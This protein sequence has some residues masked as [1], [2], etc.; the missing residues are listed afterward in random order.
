[1]ISFIVFFS[2]DD[3]QARTAISLLSR[4]SKH[5]IQ[6]RYYCF[7]TIY[8]RITHSNILSV[9]EHYKIG[10]GRTPVYDEVNGRNFWPAW[11][12]AIHA[13]SKQMEYA[14]ISERSEK[15]S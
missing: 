6:A 14:R 12:A 9:A 7:N 10:S 2:S 4:L 13:I 8:F 1:L 15:M 3:Q 5:I 11:G